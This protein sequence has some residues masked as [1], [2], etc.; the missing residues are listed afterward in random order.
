MLASALVLFGGI[1]I[2]FC[3]ALMLSSRKHEGHDGAHV[4]T[5][6]RKPTQHMRRS[7]SSLEHAEKYQ[8]NYDM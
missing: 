1:G 4:R 2:G 7:H 8:V 3:A 5:A 6:L